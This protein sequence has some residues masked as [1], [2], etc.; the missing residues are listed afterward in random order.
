[1]S[2]GKLL[3]ENLRSY[4]RYI[5]W[6]NHTYPKLKADLEEQFASI[7]AV[8]FGKELPQGDCNQSPTMRVSVYSDKLDKIEKLKSVYTALVEHCDQVLK[9]AKPEYRIILELYAKTDM[10]IWEIGKETNFS[11]A[12]VYQVIDDETRRLQDC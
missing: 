11:R 7:Q 9:E 1:M 4:S 10:S 3:K 12:R 5:V 2:G 6:L 8:D